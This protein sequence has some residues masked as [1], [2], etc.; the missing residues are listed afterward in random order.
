[1]VSIDTCALTC[2][3]LSSLFVYKEKSLCDCL[4][5]TSLA[6]G[7]TCYYYKEQDLVFNFTFPEASKSKKTLGYDM[8]HF[9][10]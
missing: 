4:V 7:L 8:T 3:G 10:F 6:D 9:W 2:I 1:M 5:E